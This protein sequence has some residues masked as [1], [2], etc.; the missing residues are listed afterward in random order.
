MKTYLSSKVADYQEILTL[1]PTTVMPITGDKNQVVHE[2]DDTNISVVS[3]SDQSFFIMQ[4]QWEYRD[5]TDRNL[6]FDWWHNPLKA[7]GRA[8]SFYWQHPV[9]TDEYY[10]IRFTTP[11]TERFFPHLIKSIDVVNIRIEGNM[12]A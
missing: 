1:N 11:L 12:P 8:R 9:F 2:Y 6:V 3:I 10:T 4:L 5:D 7:N